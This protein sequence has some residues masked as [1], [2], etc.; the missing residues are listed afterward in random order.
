MLPLEKIM[1]YN[2][3]HKVLESSPLEEPNSC[4]IN[5]DEEIDERNFYKT[6]PFLHKKKTEESVVNRNKKK[7]N[8]SSPYFRIKEN[9]RQN[10]LNRK[11]PLKEI[12]LSKNITAGNLTPREI[13]SIDHAF[14]PPLNLLRCNGN[15]EKKRILI[16]KSTK[17]KEDGE[18][19]KK[20]IYEKKE[21]PKLSNQR[22]S[23]VD[24]F[25]K[26]KRSGVGKKM[27]GNVGN[28]TS[29]NVKLRY[30]KNIIYNNKNLSF[31]NREK[32]E[33]TSLNKNKNKNAY[34]NSKYSAF[35]LNKKSH[36]TKLTCP[37]FKEVNKEN[38]TKCHKLRCKQKPH[39]SLYLLRKILLFKNGLFNLITMFNSSEII[40][41]KKLNKQ[42]N[43]LV[44]YSIYKRYF[45]K[46][47]AEIEKFSGIF[48]CV[49]NKM[50]FT[51]KEN[52]LKIDM[53]LSLKFKEN[54]DFYKS[55]ISSV[56]TFDFLY[57]YS[58]I[59]NLFL[60]DKVLITQEEYN[61]NK[62]TKY[63]DVY[64]FDI[65][66]SKSG[67]FNK[68]EDLPLYMLR[69]FSS[70]NVDN[71]LNKTFVQPILPFRFNDVGVIN[72]TVYS[73]N[74][75]FI[76]P[77]NICVNVRSRCL[78][79]NVPL[80]QNP[81][82]CEFEY[83][84]EHYRDIKY[85]GNSRMVVKQI[86][87]MFTPYFSVLKITYDNIGEYIFKVVLRAE[88]AGVIKNKQ[89]LGISIKIKES[90]SFVCNEIK[91]NNLLFEISDVFELR[92]GDVVHFFL[93]NNKE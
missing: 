54:P 77:E 65:V 76:N 57:M 4:N 35:Y 71:L 30:I 26:G 49:K 78:S 19:N 6:M 37:E 8:F 73:F 89:E 17:T 40:A 56:I 91:K 87:S 32:G 92:V 25:G 53:I 63:C 67:L 85:F 79:Y 47:K 58:Y 5:F 90:D 12:N 59:K 14:N 34:S 82:I 24:K 9:Y 48:S 75:Y 93:T 41:L 62:N 2:R 43:F 28:K 23:N 20:F 70:F 3:V 61:N 64:K 39:I 86:L 66:S 72:L 55:R 69:E 84:C 21:I 18:N 36:M 13:S 68:R 10:Y 80:T 7:L 31:I 83:I 42:V 15:G 88:K 50:L 52:D 29:N 1:S 51:F 22:C 44:N 11:A 38:D 81:R 16:F 60:N 33:V 27:G 46:I 74:N 45:V